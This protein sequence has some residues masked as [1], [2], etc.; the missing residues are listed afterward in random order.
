MPVV[1]NFMNQAVKVCA[2]LSTHRKLTRWGGAAVMVFAVSGCGMPLG[3]PRERDRDAAVE[4]GEENGGGFLFG[5]QGVPLFQGERPAPAPG[6]G[7]GGIGVNALLWRAT[8]DTIAFM[9]LSS[10]DPFGGVIITDWYAL[11]DAGG[12]ERFK[13]TVFILDHRLRADGIKVAVF[14]Q[15]QANGVWVDAAVNAS[16]AADLEDVILT[17]AREMWLDANAEP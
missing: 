12:G 3:P 13:L 14:R 17:R 15:E 2:T 4:Q 9:P 1:T 11:P 10:A 7:G 6:G 5:E 8:L 16:T